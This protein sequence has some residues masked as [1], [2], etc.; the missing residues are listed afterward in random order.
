MPSLIPS[1][2]SP[3]LAL[4]LSTEK[5]LVA[6]GGPRLIVQ[7]ATDSSLGAAFSVRV[8]WLARELTRLGYKLELIANN[9]DAFE[10]RER[11]AVRTGT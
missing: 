5:L 3:A 6:G 10:T 8:E 11:Q 7:I 9:I 1:G 4:D 2:F